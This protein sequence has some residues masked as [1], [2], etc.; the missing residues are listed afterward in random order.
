MKEFN[1]AM[2]GA[3]GLP[4]RAALNHSGNSLYSADKTWSSPVSVD[5]AAQYHFFPSTTTSTR[6]LIGS[7]VQ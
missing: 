1:A 6:S 4:L 2:L 5:T 3:S 7:S